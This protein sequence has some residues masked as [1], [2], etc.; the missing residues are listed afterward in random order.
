MYINYANKYS[1]IIST[2]FMQIL[3]KLLVL[4]QIF[5]LSTYYMVLHHKLS[6][7]EL[8][9]LTTDL[10]SVRHYKNLITMDNERLLYSN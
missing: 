4:H 1:I 3:Y 9:I 10:S 2:E 6:L 5:K 8:L 7:Y